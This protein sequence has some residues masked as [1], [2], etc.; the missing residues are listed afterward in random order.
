M[1]FLFSGSIYLMF[2]LSGAAALMYE[3]IWL[4]S[5]GLIFGGANLAVTT[6]LSVF[7]AGLA[8]GSYIIGKY[9]DRIKKP[10][11]LYGLLELGIALFAIIF[12]VLMKIY[13]SIY[14]FLAE[15]KDNSPLYLSLVR[16]LFAVFA[17]II[18]T[19]LMGGT[20]P[21]LSKFASSHGQ[22]LWTHL[23]Y[24]Y[25]INTLGAVAGTAASGFYFFR[26]Y[27][28]SATLKIAIALNVAVGLASILLQRKAPI[29]KP[30]SN[31]TFG[32]SAHVS[33]A[34]MAT[35]HSNVQTK[36]VET[37]PAPE[38]TLKQKNNFGKALPI[39]LVVAGIG[40]SGFCALG[41]EVLWT[42]ILTIVIGASVYGFTTML[43]AFLAGIALGSNAYGLFLKLFSS[44]EREM[45]RSVIGFGS[46]QIVIGFTALLVT[47][48]IRDLPGNSLKIQEYF[49]AMKIDMFGVRQWT[50]LT[51]AFFYMLI[52]AFFMGLAFPIAGRVNVEYRK[53]AGRGVGEILSCN[54]IGAIVGAAMSGFFMIY[55]F[56]IER[57][58]QLLTIVNIGYGVLVI[59]STRH[60]RL[61]NWSI[62]G[63]IMAIL[64]FLML[65]PD[66]F[67][68]WDA[69]Y[70]AIFRANQPAA[71]RTPEM[72]AEALENTDVLYHKEGVES[73][74]S[75][76]KVKGGIQSFI[77]NGRVEAS[78]SLE[79]LQNLFMLGHL[80]M[81][82]NKNP[83]K[84]LVVAL[85]S[86]MTLGATSV[87]P[88]VE[89]I[90][91][92]EIE[93]NVMGVARTFDNY[94]H[95]V[96]DNPKLRIIFNDG[97]NFLLTTREKYDVITTDPIHPWFR[98]AGYLYTT[99][100]FRL[101][102][103]RLNEG[104]IMCQWLPIYELT[105]DN[106]KSVVKT[107]GENFKYT[108]MWL[109]HDDAELI[110]SNSPIMIDEEELER[111]IQ[112]SGV[113]TDL[114]KVQMDSA[115]DFLSYF[116]MGTEGMKAFGKNG[117]INTDDNL[118]LEFSAPLSIGKG[119]LM[120]QN[121]NAIVRYR[122]NLSAYMQ[123][124]VEEES[125]KEQMKSWDAYNKAAKVYDRAHA[126]F[127][128][129]HFSS[130]EFKH[131]MDNLDKNYPWF[132]PG[133]F[134]KNELA[135]EVAKEPQLIKKFDFTLLNESGNRTEVEIAAV[136][137]RISDEMVV[138][139]FVES[140]ARIVFGHLSI[141]GTYRDEFIN[142]FVN[143]V[144][145]SIEAIY[146]QEKDIALEQGK[147]HPFSKVTMDKIRKVISNKIREKN[148]Q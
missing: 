140:R 65:Y 113:F 9:A 34:E 7:M 108:M 39:K 51:I 93:P 58:L 134:L 77:T 74:V 49:T 72:V 130:I 98:G 48:Y 22:R 19:S 32:E 37:Y 123:L 23:S 43:V 16:V 14:I 68:L 35:I 3:V 118:Y 26:F 111:R 4:R 119:S 141:P 138:V 64:L 89:Q 54:T 28:L 95:R 147:A 6:V 31:E 80:P 5:L 104:G 105:V 62:S 30:L 136:L 137:S 18:P 56:G 96:L 106:L 60:Y 146:L 117:R 13:P 79:G 97:R 73:I 85:G 25:G 91:L 45:E 125:R 114:N 71:F 67:R 75:S 66:M 88:S 102:A 53:L 92:V 50:N 24:L 70:F 42:K 139:D 20:L 29:E 86:G 61:L 87:Y 41:Y 47:Y 143:D 127:L 17:L 128:G 11:Q 81:L 144:M 116:V 83:R 103:E 107:F 57:S 109:T 99:E 52:P 122:E 27:S 82:M 112:I 76:I 40:V 145:N 101:A 100:Y 132:A 10:L 36:M 126:L 133:R 21:V 12:P 63:A 120:E 1:T 115:K 90:T 84:V 55:L 131:L 2:F 129:G 142:R 15:G 148:K 135:S 38:A 59:F 121:T 124:A 78:S 46:V 69:K 33:K 44:R 110:G 8:I 94:N